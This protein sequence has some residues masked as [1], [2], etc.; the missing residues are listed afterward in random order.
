MLTHESV[1]DIEDVS[2][3]YVEGNGTVHTL[4]KEQLNKLQEVAHQTVLA[5]YGEE[6]YQ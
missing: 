3:Q 4:T 2:P 5:D 1:L 6:W